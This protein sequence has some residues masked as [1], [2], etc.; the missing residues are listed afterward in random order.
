MSMLIKIHNTLHFQL[1]VF[2]TFLVITRF[3][4]LTLN[5]GT[6]L[7]YSESFFYTFHNFLFIIKITQKN[8]NRL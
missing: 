1:V 3:L 7:E 8:I 4:S 5:D 6:F 2:V